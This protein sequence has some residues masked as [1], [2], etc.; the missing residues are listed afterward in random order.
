MTISNGDNVNLT[1]EE[2]REVIKTIED[3]EREE[4]E[5]QERRKSGTTSD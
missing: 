1:P 3:V 5:E 4:A 2:A